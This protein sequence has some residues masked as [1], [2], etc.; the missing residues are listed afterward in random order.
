MQRMQWVVLWA[1]AYFGKRAATY[2]KTYQENACEKVP[3]PKKPTAFFR[4]VHLFVKRKP[5][6]RPGVP[7]SFQRGIKKTPP[8]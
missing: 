2:K 7:K 3:L 4:D 8:R 5:R 1:R 6:A